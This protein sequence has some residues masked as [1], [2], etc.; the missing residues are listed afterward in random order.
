MLDMELTYS[1]MEGTREGVVILRLSGPYTLNNMFLLQHELSRARRHHE[2][3]RSNPG[4]GHK[5]FLAGVNERL[6]A[7]MEMTR[8]DSLLNIRGL[9]EAEE[10]SA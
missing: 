9:V 2:L 3:P 5:L 8:V 4:A 1:C 10:T 6:R 7:L